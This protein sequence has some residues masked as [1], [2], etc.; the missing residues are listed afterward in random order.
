M[1]RLLQYFLYRGSS[2]MFLIPSTDHPKF[3]KAILIFSISEVA[4]KIEIV[5]W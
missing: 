5:G 2:E 3:P 4:T 1:K